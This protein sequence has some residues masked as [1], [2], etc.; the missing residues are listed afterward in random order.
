MIKNNFLH[1]DYFL[2]LFRILLGTLFLFAAVEK[3]SDIQKFSV[4]I[5]NYRIIPAYLANIPAIT[6]PWIELITG[7]FIL[8]GI[9]TRESAFI[10]SCML[11]VFTSAI[12]IAVIRGLDIECGCFGTLMAEQAG[13][14]KITENVITLFFS[15]ILLVKGSGKFSLINS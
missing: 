4:S 6:L 3:I 14:R 9:K 8:F 10:I 1:N 7:L 11:I 13:F 2:L 5:Q 15:I 12:I